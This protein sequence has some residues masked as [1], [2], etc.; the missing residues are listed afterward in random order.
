M[1]AQAKLLQMGPHWPQ[2]TSR[3]TY[4][5]FGCY[6]GVDSGGLQ[7]GDASCDLRFNR[8]A[9]DVSVEVMAVEGEL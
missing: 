8:D 9:T 6:T 3:N 4:F 7:A 1:E 2:R 5:T